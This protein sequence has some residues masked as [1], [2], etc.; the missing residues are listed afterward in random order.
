MTDAFVV[1]DLRPDVSVCV[2]RPMPELPA[3]L[4][5]RIEALWQAACTR[6]ATGGAGRLF[7]GRVFSADAITPTDIT[8]HVTEFRRVVAQMED[9]TL[10]GALGLRSLAVCGVMRCTDGVPVGRRPPAAIYQPGMWQLPPAGS[11]DAG[12][13]TPDGRVDLRAQVLTE[14]QE[15]LG[16]D[17]A[18]ID[19]VRPLCVVEHPG[20]HVSDVGI[21]LTTTLTGAQVLEAHR[22]AGNTE[23]DP[24]VFVP[25][26][27]LATFVARAGDTL[28]P[29]AREFLRRT[30]LTI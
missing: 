15:E 26:A 30:G 21:A 13:V 18:S 23:Y 8:G 22:I 1:H 11:V 7:N 10:F 6:V 17:P 9:P 4:E 5:A 3:A 25:F 29:P 14:L 16:V 19:A 27:G 28:V 2:V 24:L 12:A 20:S